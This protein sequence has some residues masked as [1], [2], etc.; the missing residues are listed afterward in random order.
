M[1]TLLFKIISHEIISPQI[2]TLRVTR[3]LDNL[4]VIETTSFSTTSLK[5][6]YITSHIAE[7]P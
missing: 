2:E 7:K 5:E 4:T 6:R 1:C 3:L